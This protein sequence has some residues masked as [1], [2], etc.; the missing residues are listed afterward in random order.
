MA[1]LPYDR[2][3]FLKQTAGLV[4]ISGLKPLRPSDR[5]VNRIK[6][7]T[8]GL[9]H[10]HIYGQTDAVIGG[11]GELVSCFAK[12]PELVAA[13][14]K[15]YPQVRVARSE[16][17]ILADQRIQLVISAAIPDER[18][19]LGIRVMKAGKDFMTDKPGIT[20]LEQLDE[21]RR[22]QQATKRIYSI[23][24]GE[25]L[26]NR[27]TVKAGDLVKSGIIGRVVQTIGLGPHKIN[28][29]DRPKWFFDHRRSGGIL[30]DIGA[31][32]CDQFLFFTGSVNAEIV[33]AQIGNF[34]YPQYPD[35]DD[36]GDLTLR[37]DQGTGYMR[38][39]W[40]APNNLDTWGDSRL[41]I[42]G[43]EGY[44]EIRKNVDVAGRAGGNHLFLVNN[45][46]VRYVDCS[47]EPLPYG[48]QLVDDILNRTETAMS[49]AHCFLAAELAIKAQQKA[50]HIKLTTDR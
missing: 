46:E 18:A 6:F 3:T 12:E 9:N 28:L 16:E 42:L 35:F 14:T 8:I 23:L 30:C 48:S 22:I 36:F 41:T 33:A 11:G 10:S 1:N 20:T 43:T 40:L 4:T 39:D 15:R 17:E 5:K 37:S 49:K 38:V 19:P 50:Q 45:K 29:N 31:H 34:N 47:H 24:Y 21:V 44:I 26:E 7:A 13:Y 27:A 2:R 32:H 25:R